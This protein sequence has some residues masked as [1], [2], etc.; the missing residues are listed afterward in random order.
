MTYHK[1]PPEMK[2]ILEAASPGGELIYKEGVALRATME[3]G[4]PVHQNHQGTVHIKPGDVALI[5][6]AHAYRV[7]FGT[8]Y[9]STTYDLLLLRSGEVAY[10]VPSYQV[11]LNWEKVDA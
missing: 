7:Q 5:Q 2:S 6:N 3:H 9:L 4:M 10:G 8:R 11:A 1:I